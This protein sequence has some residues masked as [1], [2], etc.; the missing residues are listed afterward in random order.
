M[1]PGYD[2]PPLMF[3]QEEI[4]AIVVGLELL[5]RTGDKGLQ[6]A[7]QRVN[8]KIADVLPD[9]RGG[10]L[11]EGRF[12]VSRFGAPEPNAAD[13]GLL[14]A[15]IRDNRRLAIGYRDEKGIETRRDVLPLAVIYFAEATVLAAWCGLRDDFRHFRSDRITD[16]SDT[17]GNFDEQADGLRRAWDEQFIMSHDARTD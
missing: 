7:A 13:M 2:L 14:R 3:D 8:A 12:V 10:E 9:L 11:A 16:C 1:R 15:A 5:H 6:A 17:G 4:E